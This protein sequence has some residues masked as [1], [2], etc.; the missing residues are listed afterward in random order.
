MIRDLSFSNEQHMDSLCKKSC[1][2]LQYIGQVISTKPYEGKKYSNVNYYSLRY[3][4]DSDMFNVYEEYLIYDAIG[5]IG[6]VG[7]T[8]GMFI[9]FSMTG[10]ISWIFVYFKSVHFSNCIKS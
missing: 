5:M 2:T 9:G 4:F 8:L 1:V 6:S 7:G 3:V 10:V